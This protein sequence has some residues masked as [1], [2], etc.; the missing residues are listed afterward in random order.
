MP[1]QL[2]WGQ[3]VHW[4]GRAGEEKIYF[5]AYSIVRIRIAYSIIFIPADSDLVP[6]ELVRYL[7]HDSYSIYTT[8]NWKTYH[9]ACFTLLR[10]LKIYAYT[11]ELLTVCETI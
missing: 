9:C 10:N 6:P 5:A 11:I 8:N 1:I 2:R 3:E 4:S 7:Y